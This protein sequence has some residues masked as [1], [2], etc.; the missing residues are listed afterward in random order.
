MRELVDAVDD[1][2]SVTYPRFLEVSAIRLHSRSDES[3]LEE[4]EATFRLFTKGGEGPINIQHLR[5]VAKEMRED[6]SD[7]VLRA[8]I[9]E[10]NG[11]SGVGRGVGIEDFRGVMVRAGVF[12]SSE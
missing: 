5:R 7:E 9:L 10:A 3:K 2:G 6:V 4:V 8:M 12:G 1:D 11:G